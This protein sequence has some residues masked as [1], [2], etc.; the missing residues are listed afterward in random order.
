MRIVVL[1]FAFFF[2]LSSTYAQTTDFLELVKAG[3]PQSVQAAIDQGADMKA[4]G[5]NGVTALHIAAQYNPN[6]EVI[7]VLVKAGADL[8][9]KD[10]NGC[11]PLLLV[12]ENVTWQPEMVRALA[13]AGADVNAKD[14]NGYTPLILALGKKYP[15]VVVMAILKAGADAKGMS[16]EAPLV[17]ALT[18]KFPPMV[19]SALLKA[20]R[21]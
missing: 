16:K 21:T 17:S 8:N 14:N 19:I 18:N 4:L 1:G 13:E 6:L 9:A 3:T 7:K 5:D 11:T 15:P 10:V 2:V 20:G 12:L